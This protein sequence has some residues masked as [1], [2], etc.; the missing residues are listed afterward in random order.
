MAQA[1][2]N[3][4]DSAESLQYPYYRWLCHAKSRNRTTVFSHS[5]TSI[6]QA[7]MHSYGYYPGYCQILRCIDRR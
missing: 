3:D 6:D 1:A 2:T 7:R 5:A 4:A